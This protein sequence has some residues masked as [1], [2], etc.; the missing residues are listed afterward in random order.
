VGSA[1]LAT[2]WKF[3]SGLTEFTCI[4]LF[5]I[6]HTRYTVNISCVGVLI[7]GL[8]WKRI[9][10]ANEREFACALRIQYMLAEIAT[11][12]MWRYAHSGSATADASSNEKAHESWSDTAA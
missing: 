4:S 3:W 5:R 1:P 2:L 12:R 11:L 7:L 8:L 6:A 10:S 9:V